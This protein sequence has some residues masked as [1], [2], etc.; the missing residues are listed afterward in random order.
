MKN[1][2]DYC[3]EWFDL[4][5]Y[6]ICYKFNR[7]AWWKAIMHRKIMLA[8]DLEKSLSSG[9][10]K[11]YAIDML[12]FFSNESNT[13]IYNNSG[14]ENALLREDSISEIGL[15]EY[16]DIYNTLRK[17]HPEIMDSIDKM[18]KGIEKYQEKEGIPVDSMGYEY[19]WHDYDMDE[20]FPSDLKITG[21]FYEQDINSPPYIHVDLN[22]NDDL[23]IN[24]FT[25]WLK[26]K[27]KQENITTKTVKISDNDLSKLAEYRVLPF[28]DLYLWGIISG[29]EFTQYQMANLL[30]PDEFD[31]DI[32][33][34][35]R[36]VTKPK[37]M[38]LLNSKIDLIM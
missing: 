6:N 27:R 22:K 2:P 11:D 29:Q 10:S 9:M 16:I 33:D 35:L 38:A 36:A 13:V 7:L 25:E 34:R 21:S 31:V 1:K 23:I 26:K 24:D 8:N 3:P 28:I 4:D 32:K 5:N 20:F 12:K 37:A 19:M 17:N 18:F 30:F 15:F 14:E